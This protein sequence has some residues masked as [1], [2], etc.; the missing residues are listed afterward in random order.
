MSVVEPSRPY[1]SALRERQA[2]QT[3][4]RVVRAAGRLFS[5]QGYHATTFA[6]IASE[7]DVS[8]ETVQKHGPKTSLLQAAVE[9]A[10]F[11]VEGETDVFA[12][13]VGQAILRLHDAEEFASLI[14]AAALS[15][16]APSAGMWMTIVGASR[17]DDELSHYQEQMLAGIRAQVERVLAHIRDRGW[18]RTDLPFDDIVETVCIVTGPEAY[19]RFVELDG[20]ST[21]DYQ[22]FVTRMLR[23]TVLAR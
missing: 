15:I 4:E 23:E 6:Q 8:V 9:L 16:N 12:T 10:S 11:G 3:R 5:V 1:R 22:A 14:G 19:V 17:G 20:R 18:L 2:A 21:D 13:E 7:A